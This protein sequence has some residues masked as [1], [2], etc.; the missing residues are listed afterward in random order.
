MDGRKVKRLGFAGYSHSISPLKTSPSCSGAVLAFDTEYTSKGRELI[1][2]QLYGERGALFIPVARGARFTVARLFASC[3]KA[4]GEIPAEV[5]LITYFSPA[6]I[7]FLPLLKEGFNVREYARGSLDCSFRAGRSTLHIYDLAR[8]YDGRSLA[9][10]AE[11]IGESKLSWKRS[12]VTRADLKRPGFRAY[13]MK[14]AEITYRLFVQLRA[15]FLASTGVDIVEAKTPAG[16]SAA[17]F[18]RLHV[19]RKAFYCDN[20]AARKAA[21]FGTWGGRA[22]VFER[23][24]LPGQFTEYDISSAY[25]R[26]ALALG[27]LPV[28]GSWRELSDLRGLGKWRGGFVHVRFEFPKSARFPC[29]PVNCGDFLMYPLTG[30]SWATLEEVKLALDLRAK[31]ILIEGF[32]YRDGTRALSDYMQW[33]LENRA[34]AKGAAKTMFKLLANSL[35]GKL[36][37]AIDKVPL[38][39]YWR[40]AE[41]NNFCLDELFTLSPRELQ[42]LGARQYVSVGPVFMPEWNGLITGKTRAVLGRMLT[43]AE[44]PIYCHTDSVWARRLPERDF[45]LPYEEKLSGRAVV[46]RTRFAALGMPATW[47]RAK[48]GAAHV[49]HHSVWNIITACQMLSRFD[50]KDFSRRYPID[51]PLRVREAAR[52]GRTPGSWVTEWRCANTLWDFK[53]R[54]LSDGLTAPWYS[55]EDFIANSPAK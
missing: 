31:L 47:K 1:S 51:R 6:E 33:A 14:D 43:V 45:G 19:T 16:A 15:Q 22:E 54:L 20:N 37:Q 9:A 50:G 52:S 26:S 28:Q 3:V 12:A 25:P 17:A 32:G 11:S 35:I 48:G 39:E 46:I 42:A 53:R 18:R 7:Q 38:A 27:K 41:E 23:G 34:K 10:A 30:R 40:L 36:A 8:W 4:L 55:V 29:L 49:A 2:Y 24:A 5:I 21:M 13:A 44:R